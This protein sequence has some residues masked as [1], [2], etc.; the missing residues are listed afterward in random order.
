M[1]FLPLRNVPLPADFDGEV[2]AWLDSL[3]RALDDAGAVQSLW[4]GAPFAERSAVL[5]AAAKLLEE[6]R[7]K[8]ARLVTGEMGCDDAPLSL[9]RAP[10]QTFMGQKPDARGAAWLALLGFRQDRNRG[11][12]VREIWNVARQ[13]TWEG[14]GLR[15][16]PDS[17]EA[18]HTLLDVH[19]EELTEVADKALYV[20]KRTGKNKVTSAADIAGDA[21]AI[22]DLE[23]LSGFPSRSLIGREAAFETV[24][25]AVDLVRELYAEDFESFG[26]DPTAVPGVTI[27]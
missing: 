12:Y 2:T 13:R 22:S 9:F 1:A 24:G 27:P 3:E 16:S 18:L 19:H 23:A 25:E 5:L 14:H 15:A 7:D 26:Y 4:S 17:W 10:S 11:H 21:D 20:S 6:R 8:L